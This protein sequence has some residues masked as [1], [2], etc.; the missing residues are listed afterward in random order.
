MNG[1]NANRNKKTASL[2]PSGNMNVVLPTITVRDVDTAG[3]NGEGVLYE[4]Q[5]NYDQ[6]TSSSSRL[7][8]VEEGL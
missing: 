6:S 1:E 8:S 2:G 4:N 3:G 7:V 5:E